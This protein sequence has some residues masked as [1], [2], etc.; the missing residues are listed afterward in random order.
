MGSSGTRNQPL[1]HAWFFESCSCNN[2][3]IDIN[4]KN[5]LTAPFSGQPEIVNYFNPHYQQCPLPG[6]PR[7]ASAGLLS[8]TSIFTPSS[9]SSPTSTSTMNIEQMYLLF[10]LYICHI[11]S[12]QCFDTVGWAK[13][14]A[15]GL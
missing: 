7:W 12:L 2:S 5:R 3:S 1:N 14:R 6:Y 9:L 10:Y 11:F 4:N 13:G 15:S 8:V